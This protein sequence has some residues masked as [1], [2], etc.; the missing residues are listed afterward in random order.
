MGEVGRGQM[1]GWIPGCCVCTLVTTHNFPQQ[2]SR[3]KAKPLTSRSPFAAVQT[4]LAQFLFAVSEEGFLLGPTRQ[5][6]DRESSAVVH[7]LFSSPNP[8]NHDAM[9]LRIQPI[10][11]PVD[12][13]VM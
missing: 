12:R 1:E 10:A 8:S 5:Q 2:R 11:A 9:L 6:Q 4:A 7:L 3:S 13:G